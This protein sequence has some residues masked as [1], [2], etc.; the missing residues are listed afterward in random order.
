MEYLFTNKRMDTKMNNNLKNIL[1]KRKTDNFANSGFLSGTV[2]G[3]T[4][5]IFAFITIILS[6]DS[7]LEELSS[8]IDNIGVSIAYGAD[9][10]YLLTL[11]ITPVVI[12]L[13]CSI[14]GLFYGLYYKKLKHKNT[15]KVY[16][17]GI[18]F[19][20]IIGSITKLP[21]DK[22][23]IIIVNTLAWLL[24]SVIFIQLIKKAKKS[25]EK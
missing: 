1:A 5:A 4:I 9:T 6:K 7:M 23:I 16:L 2:T 3:I 8:T 22:T 10:L 12:V 25:E 24:F 13:I 19:G 18:I 17:F 11:I 20:I 21:A 14:I 15:L